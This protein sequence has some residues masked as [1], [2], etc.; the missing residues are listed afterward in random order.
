MRDVISPDETIAI[1]QGDRKERNSN[2]EL[3]RIII[4]LLIVIHHYV[5]NSGLFSEVLASAPIST[6]SIAMLILGGWGKVGINC[7]IMI[8]G[9]FMCTSQISGIKLLKLYIQIVFY[10]VIIYSIFCFTGHEHFSLIR[11]ASLLFPIHNIGD[12]FVGC[13]LVFYLFIPFLNILLKSLDRKMHLFLFIFLLI[14]YSVLPTIPKFNFTFNYVSWFMAIYVMA[15]YI[16]NYEFFPGISHGMWGWIT[17][18]LIILGSISVFGMAY[19]SI[20]SYINTFA[21]Y[22]FITDSNKLLAILPA[23]SSF[24]YFKDLRIPHSRF[25]NALGAATFG[26]LLIH[27]NSDAMRKWLWR[28]IVDCIGH[29]SSSVLWTVGYSIITTLIIFSIC[30]G[31]EW[32]RAKYLE[33]YYMNY[34]K[35]KFPHLN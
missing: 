25:I 5:V 31:I 22:Y 21:P 16:R 17:L 33:P 23:I 10:T 14:V 9:Y 12:N 11:A 7:F 27:A 35:R 13:F 32:F 4:M 18:I 8:T 2:L 6:A 20:A 3:Y 19:I 26:V 15:A 28:D 34:F 1:A 29:F 30:A 24:M